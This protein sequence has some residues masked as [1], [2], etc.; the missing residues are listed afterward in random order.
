MTPVH[1]SKDQ[2]AQLTPA[3]VRQISN[4]ALAQAKGRTAMAK[5]QYEAALLAQKTVEDAMSQAVRQAQGNAA[6]ACL[7]Y[8][9]A[10]G[11]ERSIEATM[12]A[13]LAAKEPAKQEPSSAPAKDAP[14]PAKE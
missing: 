1:L 5:L 9:T 4:D 6:V 12:N 7:N 10:Q 2:I 14:S 8:E 3:D 11:A 13:M